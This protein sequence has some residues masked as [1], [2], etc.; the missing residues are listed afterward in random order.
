[1]YWARLITL[2][3]SISLS[4]IYAEK[5]IEWVP[6]SSDAIPREFE[7]KPV[8][9]ESYGDAD[10]WDK[11]HFQLQEKGYIFRETRLE[12]SPVKQ[13]EW[14]IF[15]NFP[16][17]IRKKRS[18]VAKEKALMIIWEPPTVRE[19]LYDKKLH[20]Q[21]AKIL[22]YDDDL[23][24]NKKYF[25]FH[26]PVLYAMRPD[27]VPYKEKKLLCMVTAYKRS[28]YPKEL[29]TERENVVKFFEMVKEPVFDLYG[30]DWPANIYR[31]YKG[32]IPDKYE[33]IRNYRFAIC[34]ENTGDVRGYVTEKIF[35]A[36]HAG[37]VPIYFGA[38][39]ITDYVPAD[40]FIDRR[41]Y[42]SYADMYEAIKSMGE[43]EYQGYIQR[44]RAYLS[45]E[46]AH[47]F[48]HEEFIDTLLHSLA[49]N[50]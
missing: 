5:V 47:K 22:T 32:S 44:I 16:R 31:N 18:L 20:A 38:S 7:N 42:E 33:V 45:S 13:V 4:S 12:S 30:L 50:G 21:F 3:M 46:K 26:Y 23:V 37:V 10:L 24:D 28:K 11:V 41:K 1:M 8:S 6:F 36:F 25:K 19:D 49:G 43:E 2:A 35:D 9:K 40:C 39:N 29:Y 48:S 27:V 14:V 17:F 15:N 34:F